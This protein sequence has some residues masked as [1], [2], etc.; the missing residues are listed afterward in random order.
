M[1]VLSGPW[2][3]FDIQRRYG[4][5]NLAHLRCVLRHELGHAQPGGDG[6]DGP[7][8]RRQ[9]FSLKDFSFPGNH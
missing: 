8:V 7:Y 2:R 5:R 6:V 4:W 3:L 9:G 1:G